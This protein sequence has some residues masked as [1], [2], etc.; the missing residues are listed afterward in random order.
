MFFAVMQHVAAL[1]EGFEIARPVVARIVI[2]M[3][4]RQHHFGRADR[5][6]VR[7]RVRRQAWERPAPSAPP[8]GRLFVPPPAVPEMEYQATVGATTMLASPL[9]ATKPDRS[10]QLRPVDRIEPPIL[11][12]DRHQRFSLLGHGTTG[13]RDQLWAGRRNKVPRRP[14]YTAFTGRRIAVAG[15]SRGEAVDRAAASRMP[16]AVM[17]N[18][19]AGGGWPLARP[20]ERADR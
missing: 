14:L 1:T 16:C 5:A 15:I 20:R 19:T 18:A 11:T 17:R 12:M 13:Q 8:C 3:G 7:E 4:G 2:E 9:R 6:I 10:R